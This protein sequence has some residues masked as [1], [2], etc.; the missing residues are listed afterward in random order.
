MRFSLA[1]GL[2][3]K[4]ICLDLSMGGFRIACAVGNGLPAVTTEGHL[5]L[6]SS[7]GTPLEIPV[8]VQW[9]KAWGDGWEV[10]LSRIDGSIQSE[11]EPSF[12]SGKGEGDFGA[13]AWI[14][15]PYLYREWFPVHI[16]K[17]GSDGIMTLVSDDP[18]AFLLAGDEVRWRFSETSL[19]PQ[20]AFIR[21]ESWRIDGK[22]K[23]HF[24]ARGALPSQLLLQE[25]LRR[26]ETSSFQGEIRK[27][28]PIP[29]PLGVSEDLGARRRTV[30]IVLPPECRLDVK[31]EMPFGSGHWFSAR[32]HDL[33][34]RMG[35][36]LIAH[37]TQA[38]AKSP[39]PLE[40][41][42]L[43]GLRLSLPGFESRGALAKLA[44]VDDLE[45]RSPWQCG[46]ETLDLPYPLYQRLCRHLLGSPALSPKILATAGFP[47]NA[48]KEGIRFRSAHSLEDYAHILN[49]RRDALAEAGHLPHDAAPESQVLPED[50]R[51]RL[52]T[53]WHGRKLVG[54]VALA[55]PL[56]QGEG[57]GDSLNWQA[58]QPNTPG[59]EP[60]LEDG[61]AVE[62]GGLCLAPDYRGTDVLQGL[63]EHALKAF[64]LSDRDRLVI[65]ARAS[66]TAPLK[67]MGFRK[68]ARRLGHDGLLPLLV[69]ERKAL[70]RGTGIHPFVWNL[71]M[72]GPVEWMASKNML[73][74]T[75]SERIRMIGLRWLAPFASR[76]AEWEI[77]KAFQKHLAALREGA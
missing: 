69:L 71:V 20:P 60:I 11:E 43:V 13:P 72:G 56:A 41:G 45:A 38:I 73:T 15:H 36:R 14:E 8:K 2:H 26:S 46:V 53:A 39:P 1:G 9:S 47:L 49:L 6:P 31:M 66:W 44:W 48:L 3:Q 57:A 63:I 22:Q 42:T 51:S 12:G 64:L 54:S 30:R 62:I 24:Q 27:A 35:F 52:I 25:F 16:L 65:S 55:F 50:G 32:C 7:R 61:P 23:L 58:E 77:K 76:W 17:W 28:P 74:L 59:H 21:I 67:R 68:M 40:M 10:G 75:V 5:Q 19:Q 29:W 37:A 18:E 34:G 4:V 33:N 70:I